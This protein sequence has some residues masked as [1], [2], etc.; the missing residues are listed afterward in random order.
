MG[1]QVFAHIRLAFPLTANKQQVVYVEGLGEEF[2]PRHFPVFLN[3]DHEFYGFPLDAA[4][5]SKH[6]FTYPGPVIDP[7]VPLAPDQDYTD[8]I[9]SLIREYIPGAALGKVALARTCMYR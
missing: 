8:Y 3:L 6:R 4:A 1:S 2:A 9:M 7:E 5:Y